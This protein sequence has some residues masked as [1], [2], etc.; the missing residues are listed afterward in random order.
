MLTFNLGLFLYIAPFPYLVLF[1][2][3]EAVFHYQFAGLQLLVSLD[4]PH[5]VHVVAAGAS[6]LG[7]NVHVDSDSTCVLCFKTK[8]VYNLALPIAIYEGCS[9]NLFEFSDAYRSSKEEGV[10]FRIKRCPR[11]PRLNF[12]LMVARL[13]RESEIAI[14][15]DT[16]PVPIVTRAYLNKKYRL[17]FGH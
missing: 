6:V 10:D 13:L 2:D 16:V 4:L 8:S 12:H 1:F 15:L 17:A 14:A 3:V 11:S 5:D 7:R 9:S